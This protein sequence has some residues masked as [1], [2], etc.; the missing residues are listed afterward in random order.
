MQFFG[1]VFLTLLFPIMIYVLA[2]Y[3]LGAMPG[4]RK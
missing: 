3:F 4:D 2:A 1:M